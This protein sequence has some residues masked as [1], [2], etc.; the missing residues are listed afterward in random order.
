MSAADRFQS[1]WPM[2]SLASVKQLVDNTLATDL[3]GGQRL[4]ASPSLSTG[5]H[6]V[7]GHQI[8]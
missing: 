5:P 4:Q 3:P 6:R 7:W 2:F 8:L 1:L